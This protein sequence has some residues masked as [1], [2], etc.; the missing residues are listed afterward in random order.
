MKVFFAVLC[1][2]VSFLSKAQQKN[3][4]C[5]NDSLMNEATVSCD[6]LYLKNGSQLYWQ[7]TCDRIWLTLR[8]TS[9]QT[10]TLNEVDAALYSYT[11][12]LGYHF[13]KE[14]GTKILFRS[15]CPANGPCDYV[16]ID[17]VSGK[18]IK[19]F[20]QL[21]QIDTD[22]NGTSYAF[23]FVVYFNAERNKLVAENIYNHKKTFKKFNP[24]T[25]RLIPEY[26]FTSMKV[27]G[28]KLYLYYTDS[29]DTPKQVTLS[30]GKIL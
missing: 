14:F 4:F 5:E 12:R 2:S 23:P 24:E 20:N 16:L 15:G 25:S 17:T 26:I 3:C 10:Y 13:I 9:G 19:E 6:T 8:N 29:L 27:T 28:N 21:I 1:C 18:I 11:Y 7:F 30:I 22:L